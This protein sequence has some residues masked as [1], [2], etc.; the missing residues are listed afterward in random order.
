[1][2]C[3]QKQRIDNPVKIM[4]G[5]KMAQVCNMIQAITPK[6]IEIRETVIA[7]FLTSA[8]ILA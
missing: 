8:V 2:E 7:D 1:M 3:S 6:T 4:K 5:I